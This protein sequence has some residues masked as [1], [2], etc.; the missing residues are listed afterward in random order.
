MA[1][2]RRLRIL[3]ALTTQLETVATTAGYEYD[4]AGKVFRGRVSYGE[5]TVKPWVGIFELRPEEVIRAGETVNKDEWYVG[6]QGEVDAH[7]IHP[8]DPA[9]NLMADVKKAIGQVLK[10]SPTNRNPNYMFGGLVTDIRMDGGMTFVPKE[11]PAVAAFAL[12]LTL[13]TAE[14]LENPYD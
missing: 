8:T 14:D 6:V 4:L 12:R 11:N 1:D 9:H 10:D 13:V 5:E 3:K 2:S 7:A